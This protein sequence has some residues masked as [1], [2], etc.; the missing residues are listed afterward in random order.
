MLKLI[1]AIWLIFSWSATGWGQAAQPNAAAGK[2]KFGQICA[3]CHGPDGK[4]N[5]PAAQGLAIRPKDLS[6]TKRTDAELKKIIKEGGPSAGLS[7]LMPPWGGS[8]NDQEIANLV[9]YIRSLAPSA[10]K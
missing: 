7:P 3:A 6:A 2:A 1:T 10:S 9:A 8:L 5:G 4:G